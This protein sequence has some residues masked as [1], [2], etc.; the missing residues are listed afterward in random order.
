MA[1][2]VAA[3]V[4]AALVT[5]AGQAQQP[6]A[7]EPGSAPASQPEPVEITAPL[8]PPPA[9]PPA[10]EEPAE[11]AEPAQRWWLM[12]SL[13][14]S[15]PSYLLE[16]QRTQ[17][18]G[19]VAGSY[20]VSS[21]SENN[22]PVVWSDRANEFMLQ[23]FWTRIERSVVTSDT[24]T[25]TF[26]YR[27][28]VLY[29]SDY[30]FSLMRGLWNEQ[31][32][33]A[34]GVQNLYGIDP[35]SFYVNAYVP[36]LFQGTEFRVGRHYCPFGV[37]SLEAVSTPLMSRSYAFN[38]SPPFTHLGLMMLSTFS[39]EWSANL[40]LVNGNDV[41]IDP[42]QEMRFVGSL[43]YIHPN[44]K[45]TFSFGTSL[46]RGKFNTGEPFLPTTVALPFEPAGRNNINVFDFVWT[47]TF[48]PVFSYNFECIYGYQTG[49][50]A[51]VVGG[52]IAL[53]RTSATAHWG[54][55]VHY[56]FVNFTPKLTGV[57]RLETFDDFEGQRTGFEGLYSAATI[58]LQIKP[59]KSV[60]IRPEIRYDYNGYSRP[61]EGD[62][63][64][65]FGGCDVIL[66]W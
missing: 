59:N 37:E 22:Q 17:V 48:N 7:T 63:H 20:N 18:Y 50:P 3:V 60:M 49:V 8:L 29:G 40:M 55:L 31:L 5:G 42:A 65:V 11:P 28:D 10:A 6:S 56:L 13:Q 12:K 62:H 41:F 64:L 35:I 32:Q 25:P 19:W 21:A 45:D 15:W 61:F 53:D 33:N 9:A 16:A 52:L 39:K 2:A 36:T 43:K 30:R 34:D 57:V 14:G 66:R 23:Q 54:S 46:G 47:H 1:S 58:G 24:T 44:T 27:I 51:N 38:W 4:C 26:G